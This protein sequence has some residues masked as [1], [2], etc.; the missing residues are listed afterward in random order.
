MISQRQIL[1]INGQ[2]VFEKLTIEP[3]FKHKAIFPNEACLLYLNKGSLELESINGTQSMQSGENLLL[4]CGIYFAE[5][6]QQADQTHATVVAIHLPKDLLKKLIQQDDQLTIKTVSATSIIS[7]ATSSRVLAAF[8][9]SLIIYFESPELTNDAI[10]TGKI[11]ELVL[12]LVQT[13]YAKSINDLIDQ[14]FSP[15][16]ASFREIIESHIFSSASI[17]DLAR[18]TGMSLSSFKRHFEKIYQDSPAQYIQSRKIQEACNLLL[19]SSL[20]VREIAYRTGFQDPSHFT[21]VF[22]KWAGHSPME[23]RNNRPDP[24]PNRPAFEQN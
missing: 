10:L 15:Q 18:L 6:L 8:I 14:L 11:R 16:L 5:L 17:N 21:K 2:V 24:E 20:S 22:R 12:L 1:Q 9:Q 3:P 23:F 13:N 4:K 7:P 19:R